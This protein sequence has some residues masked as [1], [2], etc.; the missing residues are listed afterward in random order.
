MPS[1]AKLLRK[2]Q[3]TTTQP[4]PPSGGPAA[5]GASVVASPFSSW[6]SGSTVMVAVGEKVV[7]CLSAKVKEELVAEEIDSWWFSIFVSC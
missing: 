3:A 1:M 6:A 2:Q 5:V 7:S 4:Y